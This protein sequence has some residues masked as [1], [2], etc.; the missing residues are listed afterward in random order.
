VDALGL[1]FRSELR[2]RWRSWLALTLLIA[3]V[4]G[5]VMASAGAGRRTAA[6]FPTFVQTH[7]YD[8]AIYSSGPLPQLARYPAVARLTAVPIAYNGQPTCACTHPV[9]NTNFN[10]MY[11]P[12]R[13][14]ARTI[15]LVSGTMPDPSSADEV[16]ASSTLQR[17]NG[18]HIGTVMRMRMYSA[19]QSEAVNNASGA[20]PSPT[21]PF[22]SLRVVGIEAAVYEFQAGTTALYDVYTTPAFARSVLPRTTTGY[23]YFVRLRHGAADVDA[24]KNYVKALPSSPNFVDVSTPAVLVANSIHPQAVG[25][26]L[27]AGLAALAGA[28]VVGQALSRTRR[29]E[30]DEFPTLKALGL[31]R[32][33]LVALG[34]AS[35]LA[36]GLAGAVGAVALAFA[37]SPLAPVGDARLVEPSS[38]LSLDGPVLLLGAAATVAMV[39]ALGAWPSLRA[40]RG[41][42]DDPRLPRSS[43]VAGLLGAAGAPPTMVVGVR[44]A[45]ERGRGATTAPVAT[46]LL[47]ALLAVTALCGTAVFGSSLAHLDATPALFGDTYQV[48]IYGT[49]GAGT[50]SPQQGLRS[51]IEQLERH[52]GVDHITKV[53]G[54]PISI[55]GVNV[56]AAAYA[57]V[58]G[59]ALLVAVS[60][61]L[62][63][64]EGE[65]ALGTSTMRQTGTHSG[66]LVP[67]RFASRSGHPRTALL[68]VVGTAALPTGVGDGEVGLGTGAVLTL[69]GYEHAACPPGPAELTCVHSIQ[70]NLAVLASA[71][72]GGTG[73]GVITRAISV[74]QGY[75]GT[76]ITP[77]SLVNFGEA[78]NF[79]LILGVILAIFGAATLTHLLVVSVGR[80]RRE[81]GLLKALGFVSR[82]V[83]ATVYW[84]ATTVTLVGLAVGVPIGIALGRV[85]WRVFALN[86]GVVP[87]PVI[88][89]WVI[90]GLIAAVLVGAAL[91]SLGPALAAA[92]ARPGRLLRTE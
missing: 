64:R 65:I 25:W 77:T 87:N 92:R 54:A 70:G 78:V 60:G 42:P 1:I 32:R 58:R 2:R 16:V 84:Q 27:L 66:A 55:H 18:V 51:V 35:T 4:G 12:P 69:A 20:G 19:S 17:D 67:V 40:A 10:V 61:R 28:A 38:G 62:P 37:L 46:A 63:V 74:D 41:R 30:S 6:A 90:A 73:H 45:L 52:P 14:V 83:G 71:P 48:I 43:A 31:G 24:F 85:I 9:D 3:V 5:V 8:A 34:M 80:R 53:T 15:N 26:W 82:Q 23:T 21:G 59:P 88:D 72:P 11:V 44:N 47:G 36:V 76:P 29:V 86:I 49:P 50:L 33:G 68:R 13:A 39:L 56:V 57:P 79:P 22:V 81:M 91:L 89:L 7:G 75:D